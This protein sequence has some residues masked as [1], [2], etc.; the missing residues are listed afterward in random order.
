M[1]LDSLWN[2]LQMLLTIFL[3]EEISLNGKSL[4]LFSMCIPNPVWQLQPLLWISI[5]SKKLLQLLQAWWLIARN[6]WQI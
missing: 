2:G 4:L 1:L 5:S 3:N 6:D